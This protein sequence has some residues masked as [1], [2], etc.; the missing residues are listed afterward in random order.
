MVRWLEAI[1][2]VEQQRVVLSKPAV[3]PRELVSE[4]PKG[5]PLNVRRDQGFRH[6]GTVGLALVLHTHRLGPVPHAHV[7]LGQ[8]DLDAEV[9]K[10]LE[11][12]LDP[13]AHRLRLRIDLF[14]QDV[15]LE[16]DR[17]HRHPPL[18][19]PLHDSV[20][21]VRLCT[22]LEDIVLIVDE[23][24]VRI[25]GVGGPEQVV[26]DPR[27]ELLHDDRRAVEPL[28][29]LAIQHRRL[30]G[31]RLVHDVPRADNALVARDERSDAVEQRCA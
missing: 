1:L 3:D 28:D 10:A 31:R 6:E 23:I 13:A 17:V 24:G 9:C 21:P 14:A 7:Y 19:Q 25:S 27:A 4:P 2:A 30:V 18:Q 15:P 8:R 22:P 20:H 16:A 26:D 12:A 11:A 5:E 29:G